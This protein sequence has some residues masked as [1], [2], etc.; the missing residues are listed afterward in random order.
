[1]FNILRRKYI[2]F[3]TKKYDDFIEQDISAVCISNRDGKIIKVNSKFCRIFDFERNQILGSNVAQIIPSKFRQA[4]QEGVERHNKSGETRVIGKGEVEL[5]GLKSNGEVFPIKLKLTKLKVLGEEYFSATINDLSSVKENENLL[6]SISRFPEENPGLVLRMHKNSSISYANL[7]TKKFFKNLNHSERKRVLKIIRN[8]IDDL[9]EI[10][11][12]IYE[13]IQIAGDSFYVNFIPVLDKFYFNVYA[14]KITDY[15][16]K[17]HEKEI[18]L[19]NLN[20]DLNKQVEFQ[21]K[22]I[23]EKNKSLHENIR[24]ARSIQDAIESKAIRNINSNYPVQYINIPH[25][26][27]SGDFIWADVIREKTYILFGDC[28]GHGVSASMITV[29]VNSLISQRLQ[30]NESLIHIM[31]KLRDDIILQTSQDSSE[32]VNVGL[33]GVL[34]SIDNVKNELEYCGANI[35]IYIQRANEIIEYSSNS[36]SLSLEGNILEN[37]ESQSISLE[38]GDVIYIASDGIRDQ[39]GG[40]K[41]KKLKKKGFENLLNKTIEQPFDQRINYIKSFMRTWQ[42]DNFQI[43]DQSFLIVEYKSKILT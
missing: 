40:E 36:F 15:I 39:F 24:F 26:I 13:E 19:R 8:K 21:V 42:G 18:K 10:R 27:V 33:D 37:F 28:T 41:G 32:G 30:S 38:D 7:A 16:N 6:E 35:P 4:H 23:R 9:C 17:I 34:L 1:M 5:E 11:K 2:N 31:S 22:E 3:V 29:M 14:V 25:S 20:K 43:D 12:P